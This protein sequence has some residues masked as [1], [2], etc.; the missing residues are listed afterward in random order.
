MARKV[1]EY[2]PLERKRIKRKGRHSKSPSKSKRLQHKK[3][4]RGQGKI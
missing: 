1:K 2:A 4:Y 3:K